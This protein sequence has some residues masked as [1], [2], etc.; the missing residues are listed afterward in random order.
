ME[1][2]HG[3]HYL[4]DYYRVLGI[5][6]QADADEIQRGWRAIQM[7]Y[8]PDRY[9]GLAEEFQKQAAFR[10]QAINDAHEVL[11]DPEKRKEYDRQLKEWEGPISNS[12]FPVFDLTK[13]HFSPLSL[14]FGP[15]NDVWQKIY[16]KL[17]PEFSGYD[18]N[19][20]AV[21]EDLYRRDPTPEVLEALRAQ[22]AKRDF[23]LALRE[24]AV[25]ENAGFL[26]DKLPDSTPLA[27]E[28]RVEARING[29]RELVG[30][31]IHQALVLVKAGDIETRMLGTGEE[32]ISGEIVRDSAVALEEYKGRAL[33]R[34]D[35]A[36]ASL[37]DIARQ[38]VTVAKALLE[39]LEIEYRPDQQI[40]YPRLAIC[41]LIP[42]KH[43]EE[44]GRLCWFHCWLEG[45]D[46]I[47]AN[48]LE[49]PDLSDPQAAAEWTESGK[50]IVYF[51][52]L[53]GVDLQD[54]ISYVAGRH[55]EKVVGGEKQDG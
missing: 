25:W 51:T 50:N 15:E 31:K 19:T 26:N 29:V 34:L 30:E 21:V 49:D 37:K 2:Q 11:K 4:I 54:Q 45:A 16:D 3:V 38:R 17:V 18:P 8:H 1:L 24:K 22:L 52:P 14:I 9:G 40:F 55:F 5:T 32:E 53:E 12:G 41:I 28:E 13:P 42:P 7:K 10:S 36:T 23:D 33:R 48:T 35:E 44:F 46:R 47:V 6:Y 39:T 20:L 43:Q 27:Y